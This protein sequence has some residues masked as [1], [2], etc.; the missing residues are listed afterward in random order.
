MYYRFFRQA[1][2]RPQVL[3]LE[4]L[5]LGGVRHLVLTRRSAIEQFH[6][7]KCCDANQEDNNPQTNVEFFIL[8]D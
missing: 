8:H 5:G 7:D 3:L 6:S 4:F 1:V 2:L